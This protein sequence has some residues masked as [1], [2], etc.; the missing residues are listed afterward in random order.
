MNVIDRIIAFL[1]SLDRSD[2]Y[3]YLAG[4]ILALLLLISLLLY[5]YY[6]KIDQLHE[7][8]DEIHE[9]RDT[10]KQMLTSAERIQRQRAEVD[11]LLAQDSGFK[12]GGYFEGVLAKLNLRENKT[13]GDHSHIDHKDNYRENILKVRLVDMDMRQLT[14]LL[15]E[16]EQNKRV[17][18]KELEIT[19]SKKKHKKIDVNLTIAALE[20]KQSAA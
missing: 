9:E 8:M 19:T 2:F 14:E 12:I 7:A 5:R 20:R 13:V 18:T 10:V 15:K 1:D 17:Y 3:K 11:A 16:L 4:F 6:V